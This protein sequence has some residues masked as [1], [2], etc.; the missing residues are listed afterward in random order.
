ML[1]FYRVRTLEAIARGE[2]MGV[3]LS[4]AGVQA[5]ADAVRRRYGERPPVALVPDLVEENAK[6]VGAELLGGPVRR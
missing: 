3:F 5:V 1:R 4:P 2:V 6:A